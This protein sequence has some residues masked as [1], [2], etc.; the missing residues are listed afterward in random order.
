MAAF[1]PLFM[2]MTAEKLIYIPHISSLWPLVSLQSAENS[3]ITRDRCREVGWIHINGQKHNQPK[4]TQLRCQEGL[5]V[6]LLLPQSLYDILRV[7]MSFWVSKR[8][9]L[10][11]DTTHDLFP[12]FGRFDRVDNRGHI[13]GSTAKIKNRVLRSLCMT[14][15]YMQISSRAPEVR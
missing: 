10:I 9:A 4:Y 12:G 11:H 1:S 7:D 14:M 13:S 2:T 6:I 8:R 5:I 3:P 15:I